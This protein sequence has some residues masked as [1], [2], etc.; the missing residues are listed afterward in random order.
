MT[1]RYSLFGL[2]IGALLLLAYLY[3]R[4]V[5]AHQKPEASE[6]F[7]LFWSSL[8]LMTAVRVCALGLWDTRL[9]LLSDTERTYIVIG[10]VAAIWVCL[11]SIIRVFNKALDP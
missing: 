7:R 8:G 3:V 10:G 6:G 5:I 1:D 2:A 4:H 11:E 9:A